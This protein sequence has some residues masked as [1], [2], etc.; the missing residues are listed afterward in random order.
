MIQ[1][2]GTYYPREVVSAVESSGVWA[3]QLNATI[4]SGTIT[5]C[6]YLRRVR[7]AADRIEFRHAAAE[8]VAVA[9]QCVEVP[10]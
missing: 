3:I 4:P 5:R 1:I 8:A 2:G 9:V 6:M 10:E 7:F